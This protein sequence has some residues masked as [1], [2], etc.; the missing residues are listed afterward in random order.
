MQYIYSMPPSNRNHIIIHLYLNSC[1]RP[2][3]SSA[4]CEWV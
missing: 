2:R 4:V 1:C 3:L